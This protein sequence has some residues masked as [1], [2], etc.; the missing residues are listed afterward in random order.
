MSSAR[1]QITGFTVIELTLAMALSVML[2]FTLYTAMRVGIRARAAA[3]GAT[4]PSRAVSIVAGLLKQDLESIQPPTGILSGAFIG[5]VDSVQFCTI[6]RD[7]AMDQSPLAEGIRRIEL[8]VQKDS[9]QPVLVRRVTRNLLPA[10]DAKYQDEILC[11]NVRDFTVRYWDGSTW[12][13]NWDSTT[14]DDS[15]PLAVSVSV[16]VI[17]PAHPNAA[18]RRSTSVVPLACAKPATTAMGGL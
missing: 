3:L 4:E 2:S 8:F 1:R 14:L 11:R 9:D 5:A 15:L 17:D 13:E 16:E 12:Q 7:D 6:G 18:P 10:M